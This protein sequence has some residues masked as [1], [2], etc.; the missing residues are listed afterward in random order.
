MRFRGWPAICLAALTLGV[1]P[2]ASQQA[3]EAKVQT[4]KDALVVLCLA[5][6]SETVVSAKGDLELRAKIK[7]ILTG[8][9]GAAAGGESQFSKKTWEGIIGGISK[10][11]TSIQSQQ[12][13]EAR[14]CMVDNGFS[15]ISKVLAGQ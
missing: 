11:M 5:G 3:I 4:I 1:A 12:A 9:I 13:I 15:L 6:G 10:D 8:N 2:A 7:D 14:K